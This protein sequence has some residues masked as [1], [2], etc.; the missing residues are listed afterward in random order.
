MSSVAIKFTDPEIV[1]QA[2]IKLVDVLKSEDPEI[3]RIIWFG[4]WTK[5]A[6]TPGSDVDLC[7]V[8]KQCKVPGRERGLKYLP[9]RFPV[10]IDLFVYTAEEFDRLRTTHP[11]WYAAIAGGEEL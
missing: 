11:H 5:R 8:V 4:S 9:R 2:V 7:V 1:R 3:Q 6:Y 10:G